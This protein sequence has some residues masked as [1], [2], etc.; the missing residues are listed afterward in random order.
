MTYPP[1][2]YFTFST[3]N[4]LHITPSYKPAFVYGGPTI[5]VSR[6][7]ESQAQLG[8][9]VTVYTT[10]ANGKTELE[11]PTNQNLEV[12]SVNVW[13]FRR[14]TGDHTHLSPSL[15]WHLWKTIHQYQAVHIHSW[16]SFLIL[17]VVVV[18]LF[19]GVR[20][21]LS[22]RGMLSRY[23]FTH[24]FSFLKRILHTLFGQILLSRTLLHATTQNEWEECRGTIPGWAGFV[25]PNLVALPQAEYMCQKNAVFTIGVLSRLDPVKNIDT[26]L[27]ALAQVDFPFQLLIAGSGPPSYLAELKQLAGA[28]GIGDSVQWLGWLADGAKYDFLA[29]LD[30]LVLVSHTENFANVVIE[31]LAVGTPVLV[32]RGV[33]LA[34]T[35]EEQGWGWVTGTD[36][37]QIKQALAQIVLADDERARLAQSLPQEVRAF[38]QTEVV[39]EKYIQ[40]YRHQ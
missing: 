40:A 19:R 9:Q 1:L 17:G 24:H 12:D 36:E 32:S 20:P 34:H 37:A 35:I 21:V 18:C 31:S 22:P 5:S 23:S 10:T 2:A 13:Y 3:L 26:L 4:I 39:V 16:W 33:G 30:L 38:F 27:G 8:H 15:W 29:H 7:C 28:S 25:A 11:V 6:L 14:M